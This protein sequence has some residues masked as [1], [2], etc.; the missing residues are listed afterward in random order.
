MIV[1]DAKLPAINGSSTFSP[2][3]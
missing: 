3:T 1:E 2:T